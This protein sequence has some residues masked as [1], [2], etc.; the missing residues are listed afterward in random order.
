[1][2]PIRVYRL[3]NPNRFHGL[4]PIGALDPEPFH[5][6]KPKIGK[7]GFKPCNRNLLGFTGP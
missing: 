5:G 1:M 2:K 3:L 6:L 4:R 7:I